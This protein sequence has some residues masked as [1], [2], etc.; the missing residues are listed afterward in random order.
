M[1]KD[2]RN[3]IEE[4]AAAHAATIKETNEQ[5]LQLEHE[6]QKTST[7]EAH[8]LMGGNRD[9]YNQ[10]RENRAYA[11]KRL[12]YLRSIS[13]EHTFSEDEASRV[14]EDLNTHAADELRPL[15]IKVQE[16][17]DAGKQLYEQI[18]AVLTD[19]AEASRMLY[20]ESPAY[21]VNMY[22]A[23]VPPAVKKILLP[24]GATQLASL[25][26]R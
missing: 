12:E 18:L 22:M 13:C 25:I 2:I 17:L 4:K 21:A 1:I 24:D 15:Y 8:A 20:R 14:Q 7:E 26:E 9:V 19:K 16:H 11:Q 3:H 6:L 10:L 23:C 5:I